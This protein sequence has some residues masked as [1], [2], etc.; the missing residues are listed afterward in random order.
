MLQLCAELA[1]LL[2]LVGKERTSSWEPQSAAE[3]NRAAPEPLPARSHLSK[4]S[5]SSRASQCHP[6]Y[7]AEHQSNACI[8]VKGAFASLSGAVR[9]CFLPVTTPAT[10]KVPPSHLGTA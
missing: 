1:V 6:I 5:P 7:P 8:V 10:V 2:M 4:P 3:P 9:G